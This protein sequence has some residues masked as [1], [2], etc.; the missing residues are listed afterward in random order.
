[1]E[2]ETYRDCTIL[3]EVQQPVGTGYWNARGRVEYYENGTFCSVNLTSA[4]NKF[5]SPEEARQDLLAKAKSW[6]DRR[7]LVH[8][9]LDPEVR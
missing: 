4:V 1:M 5:T 8:K 9:V 3:Y 2:T 6:T 7:L